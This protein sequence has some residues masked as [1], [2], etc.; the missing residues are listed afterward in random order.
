MII[1]IHRINKIDELKKIPFKY[2]VEIDIRANGNRLILNHE[3]HQDG[4]DLEEYLKYYKHSFIIFNIKETGIEQDVINLAER[5]NIKDYFLLDVE[6]PFIYRATRKNNFKK[7]AVRYSE[8]E[9]I[10]FTL[11]HKNLVDWVWIDTN[12]KLPI[13]KKIAKEL[14]GFKTCIVSPDVLGRPED[15]QKYI[16]QMKLLNFKPDAVMVSLKFGSEWKAYL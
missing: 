8:A 5:Y 15:I 14:I 13:D 2:G 12:T 7:I 4:D 9:P 6:Y 11:A 1:I 3:P 16:S 10:E